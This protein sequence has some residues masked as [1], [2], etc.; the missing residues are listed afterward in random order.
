MR[1]AWI[2]LSLLVLSVA[3]SPPPEPNSIRPKLD[4][5]LKPKLDPSLKPKLDPSLEPKLDQSIRPKLEPT[6]GPKLDQSIRPKLDP[7]IGP[8]LAATPAPAAPC[9]WTASMPAC[10]VSLT[11]SKHLIL[12]PD[13]VTGWLPRL[14]RRRCRVL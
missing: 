13:H 3:A 1:S 7:T 8:N 5:S 14:G 2:T 11:P 6:I 10:G 9:S 12:S 4:P